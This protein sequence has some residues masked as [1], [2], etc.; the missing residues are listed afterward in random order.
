MGAAF[1][2]SPY[3]PQGKAANKPQIFSRSFPD[4]NVAE[5]Q[6]VPGIVTNRQLGE[7]KRVSVRGTLPT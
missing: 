7:G 2:R 5:V 6:R 4:N 1:I 3:C